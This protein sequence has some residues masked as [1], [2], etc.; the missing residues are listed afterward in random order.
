MATRTS[1]FPILTLRSFAAFRDLVDGN[2][3]KNWAFRGQSD[4][5]WPLVSALS[6]YLT[7]AGVH[8]DAWAVQEA[9][10]LR[11]F[12]RKAHLFLSHIPPEHD[13]FQ[14]LALMQ[15]HGAPTRLLDV[16]WSPYVAL[17]FALERGADTA[18]VWAFSPA[19]LS[20][21]VHQLRSGRLVD[22]GAASTWDETTY[23]KYFLGGQNPFVILGEPKIM[24]Q[25]LI[26]QSGSFMIPGVLD[27]PV[28]R[29]LAN[30][31]GSRSLLV[32]I[33]LNA[34][35]M[36]AE[37]MRALYGMNITHATLFP[38]L[39]GLARSMAYELEF[40]W[41]YDPATLR[42]NRGYP[43][44]QRL[45]FWNTSSVARGSHDQTG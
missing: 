7:Y 24:N 11:I 10:I 44:P 3:F 4:A 14:W 18:A 38:D 39:D 36:R 45:W 31:R 13:H 42:P 43:P 40:H 2:R 5:R 30:Y 17:F 35:A 6:R 12:Q 33:E 28:E 8:P 23:P 1:R 34:N 29:I 20:K 22:R 26:A 37:A 41:A 9:R 25:R 27:P 32:K 15:H 16:T 21:R 19:P